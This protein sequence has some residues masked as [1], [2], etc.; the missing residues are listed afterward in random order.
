[1]VLDDGRIV[2]DGSHAELLGVDGRYA[3]LWAAGAPDGSVAA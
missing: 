2:E 3:R 1:M